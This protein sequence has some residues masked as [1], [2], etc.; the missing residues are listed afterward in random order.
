MHD[1]THADLACP[2]FELTASRREPPSWRI[3]RR[4]VAEGHAGILIPSFAQSATVADQNLVLW[5][6][7][8]RRPHRVQVFDPSGRLPKN[9]LSWE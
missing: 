8:P 7:G 9:Q 4:L 6:W 1:V 3:A 2:W 5:K